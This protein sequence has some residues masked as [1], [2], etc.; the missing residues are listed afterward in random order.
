MYLYMYIVTCVTVNRIIIHCIL[1]KTNLVPL[2]SF[3]AIIILL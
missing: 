1:G 2:N 3:V